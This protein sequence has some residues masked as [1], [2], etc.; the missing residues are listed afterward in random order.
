MSIRI[1]LTLW[2]TGLLAIWLF[3]FGV[4]LYSLLS[5]ILMTVLDD[6]LAGQAQYIANLV[7]NGPD[8]QATFLSGRAALPGDSGFVSQYYIQIIGSDGHIVQL[9]E[10]LRGQSLPVPAGIHDDIAART[11][12]Q[13]HRANRA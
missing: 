1:R 7:D 9:S 8:P 12:A 5:S 13:L 4:L 3:A 2:Y 11:L 6:R 10:N